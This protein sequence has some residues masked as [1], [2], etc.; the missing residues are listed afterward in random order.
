M[1]MKSRHGD[2]L[3]GAYGFLDAFNE[4][5]V[6]EIR[7]KHGRVVPDK[8]WYDDDYIGIDRPERAAHAAFSS[9]ALATRLSSLST[10]SGFVR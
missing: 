4:T 3:Y 9:L 8:G 1:A 5:F 2:N 7:L 10:S 6:S